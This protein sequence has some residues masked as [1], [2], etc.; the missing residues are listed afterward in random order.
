MGWSN[1]SSTGRIASPAPNYRPLNMTSYTL[2]L[3]KTVAT[4]FSA[5]VE[6]GVVNQMPGQ[7]SDVIVSGVAGSG[8]YAP[9]STDFALTC[10]GGDYANIVRSQNVGAFLE[11]QVGGKLVPLAGFHSA[12]REAIIFDFD[13]PVLQVRVSDPE[14]NEGKLRGYNLEPV[15]GIKGVYQGRPSWADFQEVMKLGC[16]ATLC[17]S[18]FAI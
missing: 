13:P 14:A 9:S 4:T 16:S 5:F 7:A 2:G 1:N 12:I 11:A 10:V 8:E 17:V 15:P 6:N 18:M 3:P